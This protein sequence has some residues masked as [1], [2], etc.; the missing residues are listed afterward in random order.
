M[1]G[2]IEHVRGSRWA[3]D[4]LTRAQDYCKLYSVLDDCDRVFGDS[5]CF[6]ANYCR[7]SKQ[8]FVMMRGELPMR[9]NKGLQQPGIGSSAGTGN[10]SKITG[11]LS[12]K[13]YFSRPVLE[14]L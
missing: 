5:V 8:R 2:A 14:P 7:H 9:E 12:Q 13:R 4:V 6:I 11:L 1:K 10:D 3:I